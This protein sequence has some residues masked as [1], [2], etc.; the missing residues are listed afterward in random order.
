MGDHL[1]RVPEEARQGQGSG[2]RRLKRWTI[3]LIVN[4]VAGLGGRVALKGSDGAEIQ[5]L[6]RA[7]GGVS[8]AADRAATTLC[9]MNAVKE[10]AMLL[11]CHGEMGETA[12]T[13]AGWA[14][15]K[16]EAHPTG[17]TTAEDTR[18]AAREMVA[19]GVDLILFSGGD[20]TARDIYDAVGNAQPV[21]GIP[22]GVKIH[23]AAFAR[24]AAS[25][26]EIVS[27]LL[28]GR[29]KRMADLEVMD[30]DEAKLREGVVCT[31]LYGLLRVPT[32]EGLVQGAKAPSPGSDEVQMQ[33]IAQRV[34]RNLEPGCAYILGPGSTTWRIK[35]ALGIEGTLIG[36]DVV[37]D[38]VLVHRDADEA[39]LLEVV[40]RGPV[41]LVLT[42]IGGQG[43]LLGRGNQQISPRLLR[44]IDR[45]RLLVVAVPT[46]LLSLYA[47]ALLVDTGDDEVDRA[48]CGYLRVITGYD[49]ESV[50]P[51]RSASQGEPA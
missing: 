32:G 22:A 25:A 5:A 17:E 39:R 6:A 10:V 29:A 1:A 48:L 45:E 16:L 43:Y 24:S 50:C 2:G 18:A 20:G 11:T 37:R 26:G 9:A 8:P 38:G 46:K 28:T 4:P 3:G 12:A 51:V 21:L 13:R 14:A 23:S 33:A 42:P 36:V 27:Q 40:A 34:V 30:I 7:R 49:E 31:Q 47:A 19:R 35:Q 44:Q 15:E 41:R